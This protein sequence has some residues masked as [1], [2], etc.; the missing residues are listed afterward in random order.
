MQD[1]QKIQTSNINILLLYFLSTHVKSAFSFMAITKCVITC[2]TV[3]GVVSWSISVMLQIK[4]LLNQSQRSIVFLHSRKLLR[5]LTTISYRDLC[6][7]KQ[8]A[9]L[10]EKFWKL[11][12]R[13]MSKGGI[14]HLGVYELILNLTWRN[15]LAL[16]KHEW[17]T[18]E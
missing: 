8:E 13:I 12:F 2:S 14:R 3:A 5:N 11:I 10:S 9:R 15:I 18:S 7:E 1:G 17:L 16:I 4:L 6:P